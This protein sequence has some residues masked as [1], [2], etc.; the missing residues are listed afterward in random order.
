MPFVEQPSNKIR[1]AIDRGGTFTDCLG[2]VP[3]KE[4]ILI[5]LLSND[6]TNYADAPT[7]GIRRILEVA[8]GTTIPRGQKIDTSNIESI[9]MGTTVATNALLERSSGKCALVVTRGFKDLLR[10]GDQTRPK[11][12]DLNI[13]RPETLFQDV[14]E[15]EERVTLHDSTEDKASLRDP[16]RGE[17]SLK[18]GIGGEAIRVL[19]PLNV[20][21]A[22]QGLQTLYNKGVRSLAI[23]LLH[24]YTFPDHELRVAEVAS[25]IGF[26]QISISSQIFPMI[27][28]ISR[29]YS[30]TADAYLTPLTRSYIDGFRNGF[31]G[32]LESSE[33]AR[34]EFMQSD[35]GLVGWQ[36]FSGLKAI[37]SG[38][39]GGVVG[40]S[41]TCY[42]LE[43]KMPVIGFDMGGTSTDVSRYAG[44]LEHTF[45]SMTAGVTI[46]SPQLE[47]DTVA[48]GGGS[49]LS[50]KNRLFLAGPESASAH[51]GPVAYRKGGPLTV[52]DANL[53]LG[54]LQA[55]YFP[56]IFGKHEDEP[57]DY[58]GS[59]RAFEELLVEVNADLTESGGKTKAVEELAL[60]FLEVA[61]ETMCRPI[62]A[63]T[64]A[65]GYRTS[66][67]DLAV[68]GGAGG[69]HACAI[70]SNLGIDRVLI[71]RYS[72]ILSAY[73]M[74][75]ADVVRDVQEPC[76]VPLN[77]SLEALDARLASLEKAGA[78]MLA[79]DGFANQTI[80][81]E[82][83]LNL[84]YDGSDT[85]F[86]ISRPEDISW[87]ESFIAEHKRQFSFTMP[88][89]AILVENVR[90]RATARSSSTEPEFILEKQLAE[91][92]P[93]AVAS[94]VSDEVKV[95]FEGGWTTAP[96][97]YLTS[98]TKGDLVEGPAIILDNTQTIVVTPK[99]KAT[100]LNRHVVLELDRKLPS[101]PV[102]DI[103]SP[104]TVDPVEL[105]VMAHRFMS[106]AEQMGHALQKTSVS[107]NIKERLDFSCALF[108]PDGR[109]VANAPHVP[110]HLGSMEQ[111]VMYQHKKYLGQLRSGDV[112]VANH[113]ISGGTHLPD[114]TC[115]T[116]VFDETGKE[117]IFYTA[118]RGHHQ[119]IGGILPGSMPAGSVELF[120][121]GAMIVS[122]FLVRDGKFDE[123]MITRIMLH[124]P[125]Q[126]SGCSGTR[127][128]AD[129]INDLKAQVSANAKGAA[130]MGELVKERGLPTVH[131]NMHAITS[132][133]EAIVRG[134]LKKVYEE[135]GKT[136]LHALDYMDDGTPIE[137]TITINPEDG[138]AHFDFT[139]TG[140]EGYHSFNAP[141]AIA[142]SATLYVLRCL[143][144]QDIPL[145]EGCLRP[146]KFT[147][148]EGSILNPSPEAA[149]CA[150]NP[151]T[152][153]R[154][155][156]VVI[157]AFEACAASQGDCNVFSFGIDGDHDESGRL[158]PN[159][160]FGFGE[161]ICGG[162]GAGP[163]WHGTSGIHIHMT[164][165]R[166][167]DPE[168]LEK[169][170]PVVLR[171]FSIQDGSGGKG[172]WNGGNGIRR[173]YEFER[174]V[175]ASI[176][177]ERRV[178]RPY[179]MKGGADGR[180][181]VNYI[182]KRGDGG[183]WC[184]LGGRKDF[185]AQKGDW[186]VVDT[187]G[188]GGW[189]VKSED[190][191][192]VEV[193]GKKRMVERRFMKLVSFVKCGR[194]GTVITSNKIPS[195]TPLPGHGRSPMFKL[196][197][198]GLAPALVTF[199]E[200][201]VIWAKARGSL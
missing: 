111:A 69:Q 168:M 152:S 90:V 151:I 31:I 73:G 17:F 96:L 115:I 30:A 53:V 138:S 80:G 183:R 25:Q 34:C 131:L 116:P 198:V 179:G 120:E 42:D 154:V 162:S 93:T 75:L 144:N 200:Y 172:R 44:T 110:V 91:N 119:E 181:G 67:H 122:E 102:T 56:K 133:A 74:A 187:P 199:W 117:I 97:Y 21:Q 98:L 182:V 39:A 176:V 136:K 28:A 5:K 189:G 197:P 130:L 70:A 185:R 58:E 126:Y 134:F 150:G 193:D 186:F 177:S 106:I 163:G 87:A 157:R 26:T 24:S 86:M 101:A 68:F 135:T 71:H 84:R 18:K 137:L 9:K 109:L 195:A 103:S 60:G 105:T 194:P 184:R 107:V 147:I 38:P 1:I 164:N 36:H 190:E 167:T 95:F 51:P 89:R 33:G 178:T 196:Y 165:T 52:T 78:E 118:S 43:R 148:P 170:Y 123:D 64:E 48:A 156:D 113:P 143:I 83:F 88:G 155:T 59:R 149:V 146:L 121:E 153:Q 50:Y 45:E 65:K 2:I 140:E 169:R 79:N 57:L 7:E 108:S 129:N 66:E 173:I 77:S 114:I 8:T 160:G 40:F 14:L 11:L 132:N 139:G 85:T 124:D 127:K 188:G 141:Q 72:S 32:G 27:K 112:I 142:R 159:S 180:S 128:L 20:D 145:N 61:N 100:I 55:N 35:G 49:I 94:K 104:K 201:N 12:F 76:S 62:R 13:R 54:R 161:T 82:H 23:T 92:P 22:R 41:K 191:V 37:L 171:E 81:F 19:E 192:E 166:I 175:N 10:I 99:T 125:A 63:L 46:Q 29:G 6:P 47:I 16:N 3:E 158:I 15:V 4:D 174:D